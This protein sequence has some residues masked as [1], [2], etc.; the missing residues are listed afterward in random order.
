MRKGEQRTRRARLLAIARAVQWAGVVWN[1]ACWGY[2]AWELQTA[3]DLSDAIGDAIPLFLL[4][5]IGFAVAYFVAWILEKRAR[6]MSGARG[7]PGRR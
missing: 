5:G 3:R 4:G 6:R 2:A 1:F 7:A